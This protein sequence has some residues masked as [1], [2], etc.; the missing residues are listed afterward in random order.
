MNTPDRTV[1]DE[2]KSK[3]DIVALIGET[4][5][6]TKQG[7]IY[8]GA[9]SPLSKSGASLKVDP[10][11]QLYNNF[12]E[13]DGGDVFN[14]IAYREGLDIE[15]DFP[16][17]L[18]IAA[19]KAGVI[20]ESQ[21]SEDLSEKAILYPFLRA[22]A[23]YYHTQLTP[24]CREYIHNKW[25]ISDEMIDKLMIGWAPK[26]NTLLKEMK[27]LFTSDVMKMS[28]LFYLDQCGELHNDFFYNRIIFPYWKGGRPVYFIG[29]D[30]SWKA[31]NS[32]PKYIK[33]LVHSEKNPHISKV[34]NNSVFYGEDSIKKAESVIITEGVTDCIKVL[35]EG[36]ACISPV[37]IKIK[38]EQKEYACQLVRNKKEVI[39][40][41][42]N[43]DNETGEEGAI[44]TAEYLE[45][46]GVPVRVIELPRPEGVDKIDLAE[47][48]QTH[49]KDDFLKL[50]GKRVWDIKLH[51]QPKPKDYIDR[52][53][54]ATRFI[55]EE[56]GL[57]PENIRAAFARTSVKEYFAIKVSE[58]NHIL[59]SLKPPRGGYFDSEGKFIPARMSRDIRSKHSICTIGDVDEVVV[60]NSG[61]GYYESHG[62]NLIKEYTQSALGDASRKRHVD[63]TIFHVKNCTRIDRSEFDKED[64][65][66]NL[67]NGVYNLYTQG[68]EE[69]SPA[70]RFT[71]ALPFNYDPHATCGVFDAYLDKIGQGDKKTLIYEIFGYCLVPGY[72]I[73]KVFIFAGDGGNG[74]GTVTRVMRA[75]LGSENIIG[76]GLQTLETNPYA[77][78]GFR[79]KLACIS[80]ESSST[81]ISD[82]APLKLL[83]GGDQITAQ[84]IYKGNVQF[85]NRAKL[86]FLMNNIPEF[87]DHTDSLYR[88]IL[89]LDF[90]VKVVG[91]DPGFDESTLST[92]KEL[93]GIFNK[94][95]EVLPDLLKRGEFSHTRT[96]KEVREY[97]LTR[98]NPVASFADECGYLSEEAETLKIDLYAAYIKWCRT[99]KVTAESDRSFKKLF[100][101]EYRGEIVNSKSKR[102]VDGTRPPCYRGY[103]LKEDWRGL[104]LE[105]E[106]ELSEASRLGPVKVVD[107]P[108]S[109]RSKKSV[110][111]DTEAT[112]G[113]L[114]PVETPILN[115]QNH[116]PEIKEDEIKAHRKRGE[117]D[118]NRTKCENM[119]MYSENDTPTNRTTRLSDRTKPTNGLAKIR[120]LMIS[121]ASGEKYNGVVNSGR[122]QDF[123]FEFKS[124]HS[125]DLQDY[126]CKD[127][128]NI[129][130]KIFSISPAKD[131]G[132]SVVQVRTCV[133]CGAS[134][135]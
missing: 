5:K 79:G 126:T 125:E 25:G 60:Y 94:A 86:V 99:S 115:K 43:E 1:K 21:R 128:E 75:F 101:G 114:C 76:T 40:C 7:S 58:I 61:R 70:H 35:Q 92:D 20:L 57:M 44:A 30:P 13:E 45:S 26:G 68:F 42:D 103:E 65:Y 81:S 3:L 102:C 32:S 41:N 14:W 8:V 18:E 72:P 29:R 55:R 117:D 24:G 10:S 97:L 22:A 33:Q 15:S 34:I 16:K 110:F 23:G 69:H 127:I 51:R 113:D 9:T 48:L 50:G 82:T 39:V 111:S 104:N 87:R 59:K 80:G 63:E 100:W 135:A 89:P 132:A 17:I 123:A 122:L 96:E 12:A 129:A 105:E 31:G 38:E 64:G 108:V 19:E 74:K 4:V 36:L 49:T 90:N 121:H 118:G 107:G 109:V 27:G 37:T 67:N 120:E 54:T 84:E 106:L 116:F 6:L 95:M 2:V 134:N 66:I 91:M 119:V 78:A 53:E 98:G 46:N 11:T 77:L 47:Y 124:L 112:I 71:Y 62:E 88:C 83:R 85:I 93:S 130:A 28:G 56:L 52:V 131:K 73:Q 133:E